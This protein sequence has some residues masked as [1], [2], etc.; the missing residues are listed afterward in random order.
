MDEQQLL[1]IARILLND[2]IW[3]AYAL[4]DLEP[5]FAPHAEWL[6][7]PQAVVLIYHGLTPPL[8]FATGDPDE[9]NDLIKNRSM[10]E[11]QFALLP[12]FLR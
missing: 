12:V 4:A 6:V 9:T 5:E 2:P 8:L 3:S 7:S 10:D 11:C 1:R